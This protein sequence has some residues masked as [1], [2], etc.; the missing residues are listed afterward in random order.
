MKTISV[1]GTEE[2]FEFYDLKSEWIP[3]NTLIQKV[4]NKVAIQALE[5]CQQAA[6]ESGFSEMTLDEINEEL[7]I[8]RDAKSNP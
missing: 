4:K 5:K 2:D 3:L 7:R 8:I 1:Q 6:K